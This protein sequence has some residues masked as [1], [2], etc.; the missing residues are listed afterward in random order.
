MFIDL[1]FSTFRLSLHVLGTLVKF[2]LCFLGA[3]HHFSRCPNFCF[4]GFFCFCCF[5][6]QAVRYIKNSDIYAFIRDKIIK[7]KS[8][9]QYFVNLFRKYTSF[10]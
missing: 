2:L 5:K 6:E 4:L 7:I 3:K 8:T 10:Y 1:L 9:T